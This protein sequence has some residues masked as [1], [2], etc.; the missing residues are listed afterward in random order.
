MATWGRSPLRNRTHAQ[1]LEVAVMRLTHG[2][3]EYGTGNGQWLNDSAPA[4]RVNSLVGASAF[5]ERES[6]TLTCPAKVDR[7]RPEELAS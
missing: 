5:R 7:T 4:G 2:R 6:L 3:H 1:S